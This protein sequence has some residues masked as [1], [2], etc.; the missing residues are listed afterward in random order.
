[1]KRWQNSIVRKIN[2]FIKYQVPILHSRLVPLLHNTVLVF[3]MEAVYDRKPLNRDSIF[4]QK[5][6]KFSIS[7]I[8]LLLL[9]NTNINHIPIWRP[10]TY[11]PGDNLNTNKTCAKYTRFSIWIIPQN[12][13]ARPR[14]SANSYNSLSCGHLSTGRYESR[15]LYFKR[16]K[17]IITGF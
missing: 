15:T 2:Y 8:L 7:F 5:W 17:L 11:K 12:L 3:A 4:L 1:M 9:F 14:S 10:R 16:G 6:T 13:F